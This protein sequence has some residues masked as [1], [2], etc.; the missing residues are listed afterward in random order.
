MKE[1]DLD[2]KLYATAAETERFIFYSYIFNT[3][4]AD[5]VLFCWLQKLA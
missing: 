2:L 4:K 3:T 1:K 5:G